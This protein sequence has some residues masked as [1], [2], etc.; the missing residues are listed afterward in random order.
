MSKSRAEVN[1]YLYNENNEYQGISAEYVITHALRQVQRGKN[2]SISFLGHNNPRVALEIA[3]EV[4]E[5]GNTLASL[6][7]TIRI[8]EAEYALYGPRSPIESGHIWGQ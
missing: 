7:P 5:R 8:M 4:V 3:N 1:S 2:P 6:D